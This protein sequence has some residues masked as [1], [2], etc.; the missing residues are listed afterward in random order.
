[1]TEYPMATAQGP[2]HR[3]DPQ[4]LAGFPAPA[5]VFHCFAER[6]GWTGACPAPQRKLLHHAGLADDEYK[7]KIRNQKSQTAIAGNQHWETPD[8]RHA[9]TGSTAAMIKPHWDL[10]PSCFFTVLVLFILKL[11]L[12]FFFILPRCTRGSG[13]SFPGFPAGSLR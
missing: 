4:P 11:N 7:N 5:A 1:M 6:S 8:I 2:D 9:D 12:R 13:S 10:N 3:D